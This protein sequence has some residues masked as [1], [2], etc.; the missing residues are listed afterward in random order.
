MKTTQKEISHEFYKRRK[1]NGL[2]PIC[3]KELDREGHYCSECLIKYREYRRSN[4]KFYKEHRICPVCGK[5]ELYGDERNCI[6]CRQKNYERKNELTEEQKDKYRIRFRT[7]QR[8]LY[9]E[10]SEKGICTRCGKFKA[11]PTKRKCKICLSKDAE[12]HRLKR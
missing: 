5:E 11:A 12:L 4:R 2:C 8:N 1:D 7:Q 3:G 10:R 9:K 6:L